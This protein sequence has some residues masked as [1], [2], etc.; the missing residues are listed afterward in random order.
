MG[1]NQWFEKKNQCLNRLKKHKIR[2]ACLSHV[3][4]RVNALLR[5][6]GKCNLEALLDLLQH[7]HVRLGTDKGDG[8]TLGTETTGTTDAVKIGVGIGRQIIVDG[9][10]D[11]LNINTTTEDISGNANTLVELLE[12]LVTLDTIIH[13][14]NS[15]S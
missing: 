14:E 6:F 3:G 7:L 2:D 1:K 4:A 12:L 8:E 11:T 10:V 15:I 13:E 9:Q 5:I